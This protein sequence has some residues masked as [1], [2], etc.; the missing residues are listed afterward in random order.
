MTPTSQ[1][2]DAGAEA[3]PTLAVAILAL[4]LLAGALWYVR[5]ALGPWPL[6][7]IGLGLTARRL[8]NAAPHARLGAMGAG[9]LLFG[10]SALMGA[11]LA[12]NPAAA[13][14]KFWVVVGGVG[15]YGGFA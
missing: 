11:L 2:V 9:V 1:V 8:T 10:A 5:P 14:A 13:W 6:L 12:F 3:A 7:L 4:P 15:L